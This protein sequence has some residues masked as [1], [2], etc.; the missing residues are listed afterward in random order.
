MM[1]GQNH[2]FLA[3]NHD[4]RI[5]VHPLQRVLLAVELRVLFAMNVLV[6]SH[7]VM[8]VHVGFKDEFKNYGIWLGERFL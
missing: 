6:G 4:F 1:H 2:K 5:L 3:L 8:V 7:L